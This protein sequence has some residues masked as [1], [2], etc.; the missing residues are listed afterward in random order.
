[1]TDEADSNRDPA[2]DPVLRAA[3]VD[4][5]GEQP[6]N[7]DWAAM[8]QRARSA[9]VFRLR[10]K[11]NAAPWWEQVTPW[12]RR[13]LPAGAVAA[14]AALALAMVTPRNSAETSLAGTSSPTN[15]SAG[16]A[17][18]VVAD[19]FTTPN[20]SVTAIAAGPVDDEWLWNATASA[21]AA[22]PR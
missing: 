4:A 13:L 2:P 9:A 5:F 12:A 18:D 14:A 3:L 6:A 7:V 11:A 8:R 16:D 1:M 10:A 21:H 22:E 19:A 17:P 20:G 15:L